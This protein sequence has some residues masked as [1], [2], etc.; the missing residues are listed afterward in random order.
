MGLGPAT[1]VRAIAPYLR[2]FEPIAA[3]PLSHL[4]YGSTG[5]DYG[6]HIAFVVE[7]NQPFLSLAET[8]CGDGKGGSQVVA[9]NGDLKRGHDFPDLYKSATGPVAD[10]RVLN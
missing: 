6:Q 7:A 5:P 1:E 9:A 4:C 10:P 8:E 3:R 2:Q